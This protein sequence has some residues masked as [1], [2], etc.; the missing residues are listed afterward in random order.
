LLLGGAAVYRC[1][2]W[3]IFIDGFSRWGRAFCAILS[4]RSQFRPCRNWRRIN[5]AFQPLRSAAGGRMS[6]SANG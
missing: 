5:A 6:F 4:S 2:K 3:L 1:G